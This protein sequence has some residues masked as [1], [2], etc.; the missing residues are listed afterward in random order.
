[1][2]NFS[3]TIAYF[4][5]NG[6]S[7]T[8]FA[9]KERL[10]KKNCDTMQKQVR[11]YQFAEKMVADSELAD[12]FFQKKYTFSI[13][14]PTYETKE[15]YLRE[16]MDSVLT[17]SYAEFELI[18]AD[19]SHSTQVHE[20]VKTYDDP[21]IKYLSL[22]ENRGIS[23]NTNEALKV[24][25][26]DYVAL[27]DHDDVLTRHALHS[28]MVVL[29]KAEYEMIYSDEDKCNE[30]TTQFFDPH[31]KMDFNLDLLLSNNYICHF[32]AIKRELIQKLGFRKEYDGAQDYDLV[33]RVVA[34]LLSFETKNLV[35][36]GTSKI[37]HIEE[38]LYHWRCH[39]DSTA[40]NP[41]S[42]RYAYEAGKRA[43]EDFLKSMKIQASVSHTGHLGFYKVTYEGD[44]FEQ[45]P[46]VY[47]IGGRVMKKK[48]VIGG[49]TYKKQM[50]FNG[51]HQTYSGYMHRA[52]LYLQVDSLDERCCIVRT[53]GVKDSKNGV[54]ENMIYV[55]DPKMTTKI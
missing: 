20:V 8:L 53:G 23:E 30:N 43:L 48:L 41:E 27:L 25:T 51:L 52:S 1:M 4:K 2:S 47:A 37:A 22:E 33:L 34:N 45:R 15:C 26:G 55:Y 14:V 46:E 19:A 10:D 24:A 40:A 5:R 38:V 16:M 36:A 17:Q 44:I 35:E 32:M 7:N 11:N 3:K 54:N 9:V 42:K 12:S 21:R 28:M 13:L 39:M 6:F 29:Q 49:P 18:L 31:L 50:L